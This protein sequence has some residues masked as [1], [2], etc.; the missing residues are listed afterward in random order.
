[1]DRVQGKMF[2]SATDNVAQSRDFNRITVE[3]HNPDALENAMSKFES[4][5]APALDRTNVAGTF[6]DDN[7]RA[8]VLNLIGLLALRNPRWRETVRS[9]RERTVKGMMDLTL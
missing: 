3:G 9:F 7:D 5:V 6:V 8:L 1:F 4:E 2:V